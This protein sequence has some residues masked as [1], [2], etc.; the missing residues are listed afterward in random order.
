MSAIKEV[1][2]ML[3][4]A[5]V[6]SRR[7]KPA[8][9]FNIIIHADSVRREVVDKAQMDA[10]IKDLRV[11]ILDN[12][13]HIDRIVESKMEEAR[14]AIRDNL[15]EKSPTLDFD[16]FDVTMSGDLNFIPNGRDKYK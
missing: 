13:K 4:E 3:C 1:V 14:R 6:A 15:K 10:E 9:S 2:Y 12:K 16:R 8:D 5:C 11:M 7:A